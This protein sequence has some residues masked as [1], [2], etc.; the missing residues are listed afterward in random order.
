MIKINGYEVSAWEDPS[1]VPAVRR[2]TVDGKVG[3]GA[4]PGTN[5]GWGG[6]MAM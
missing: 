6:G 5:P 1:I 3:P 2:G 4:E